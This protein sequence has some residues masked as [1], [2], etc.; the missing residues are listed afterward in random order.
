M[1]V[2]LR[3][4]LGILR[5]AAYAV[6]QHPRLCKWRSQHLAVQPNQKKDWYRRAWWGLAAGELLRAHLYD[7]QQCADVLQLVDQTDW[8]EIDDARQH[9]G[10]ILAGAHIGPPCIPSVQVEQ[11][12][13]IA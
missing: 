1:P 13:L 8:S 2:P 5:V 4:K 10:V 6:Q 9:G 3:L 12:S 11:F 7:Q